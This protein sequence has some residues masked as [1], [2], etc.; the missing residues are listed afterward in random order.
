MR[1]I[2]CI[3][4]AI[5]FICCIKSYSQ[6][7]LSEYKDIEGV[8]IKSHWGD[9]KINGTN[10]K[11][12]FNITA[13]YTDTSKKP[14]TIEDLTQYLT[15]EVVKKKLFIQARV[16]QGFESIDL[17][18]NLPKTLFLE[19]ELLRGGNIF[20]SGLKNGVEINSLNGSIKLE[21]I[22]KYALVN[23]ANGEIDASFSHIDKN[24]PISL[25]TMNGGLKITLPYNAERD[26]RLISRKNGYIVSDFNLDAD[27]EIINLNVKKYSKQ[28][29][30]NTAKI[31]GGGALLFL[32]TENGPIELNKL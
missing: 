4:L 25:V 29:I 16:P 28:P 12:E 21:Q 26:I 17:N 8:F 14:K 11:E 7:N 24:Y 9:I 10:S 2:K 3:A 15:F 18:L 13:R 5:L 19:I 22:G 23:A 6:K 27:K 20:A 1:T 32:S 31:N 30:I